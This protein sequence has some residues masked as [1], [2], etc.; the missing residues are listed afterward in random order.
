MVEVQ[1]LNN[2]LVCSFNVICYGIMVLFPLRYLFI[3]DFTPIAFMS[4][5]YGYR[6]FSFVQHCF[7]SSVIGLCFLGSSSVFCSSSA[8]LYCDSCL[9]ICAS[10]KK[11]CINSIIS[12]IYCLIVSVLAYHNI[13]S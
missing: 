11:V 9:L 13:I 4:N 5:F 2:R 7:S 1:V 3:R 8:R 6:I 10:S 12:C